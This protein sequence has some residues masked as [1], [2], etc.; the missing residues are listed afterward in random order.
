M[1]SEEYLYKISTTLQKLNRDESR[2]YIMGLQHA[3]GKVAG[4]Q[5]NSSGITFIFRSYEIWVGNFDESGNSVNI[6]NINNKQ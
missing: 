4:A 2:N 1:K 6:R 5:E 3:L